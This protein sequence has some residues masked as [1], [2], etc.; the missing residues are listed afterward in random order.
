M[1]PIPKKENRDS[2][3]KRKALKK[4][5]THPILSEYWSGFPASPDY[6]YCILCGTHVPGSS[7]GKRYDEVPEKRRKRYLRLLSLGFVS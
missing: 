4:V 3:I 1:K 5:C 7:T 6:T 2:R